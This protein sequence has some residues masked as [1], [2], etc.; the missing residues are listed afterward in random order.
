MVQWKVIL[1]SRTCWYVS[2]MRSSSLTE[3]W[4]TCFTDLCEYIAYIATEGRIWIV[5][6]N[7]DLS[8]Y[9]YFAAHNALNDHLDALTQPR[10]KFSPNDGL[11]DDTILPSLRFPPE[12]SHTQDIIFGGLGAGSTI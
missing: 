11:C 3:F 1:S 2:E 9:R 8:L 10:Q 7:S 4:D 5:R 12:P 6:S